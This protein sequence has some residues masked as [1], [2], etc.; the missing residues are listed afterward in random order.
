MWTHMCYQHTKWEAQWIW[1]N[2]SYHKSWSTVHDSGNASYRTNSSW[3]ND[4]CHSGS[5]QEDRDSGW[6]RATY[7]QRQR[8]ERG[9]T[10]DTL[11]TDTSV[12]RFIWTAI[13][14]DAVLLVSANTI[15]TEGEV[16]LT[17][18]HRNEGKV[19]IAFITAIGVGVVA[20]DTSVLYYLGIRIKEGTENGRGAHLTTVLLRDGAGTIFAEVGCVRWTFLFF[21]ELYW[22]HTGSILAA[23]L[24]RHETKEEGNIRILGGR[25]GVWACRR[26]WR[27]WQEANRCYSI[28]SHRNQSCRSIGS[29]NT[30]TPSWSLDE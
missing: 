28:R 25:W 5:S 22:C 1:R 11:A 3:R 19:R 16:L 20:T 27:Y 8:V 15:G 23:G 6:Y 21:T 26:L 2:Q 12:G 24:L 18:D 13:R 7:L 14:V 30:S 29:W 9:Y 10:R 4:R 17:R